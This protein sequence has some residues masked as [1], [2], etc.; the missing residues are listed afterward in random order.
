LLG[1]AARE[2]CRDERHDRD[3]SGNARR[4]HEEFTSDIAVEV[5]GDRR[6]MSF[7][8]NFNPTDQIDEKVLTWRLLLRPLGRRAGQ[9]ATFETFRDED[10]TGVECRLGEGAGTK[11]GSANFA[12]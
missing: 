10:A 9:L 8:Y 7:V 11:V 1:P 3:T 2:W 4:H 6:V 12:R 5:S